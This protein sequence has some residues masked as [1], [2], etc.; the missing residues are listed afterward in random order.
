MLAELIRKARTKKR[1]SLTSLEEI[2]GVKASTIGAI[3][4][5]VAKNPGYQTV[6]KLERALNTSFNVQK[7]KINL[8]DQEI[9]LIDL[10]KQLSDADK[11]N[12]LNYTKERII[13]VTQDEHKKELARNLS[14]VLI[15]TQ[16]GISINSAKKQ[17][18]DDNEPGDYWISMAEAILQDMQDG[19]LG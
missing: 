14:A 5:G 13:L 9:L 2:S 17:Y 4:Q 19:K 6:A 11:K 16:L 18:T 3:E 7:S 8:T 1:L 12:T 15:S 10:F